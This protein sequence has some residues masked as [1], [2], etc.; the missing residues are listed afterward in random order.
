MRRKI[1]ICRQCK[2]FHESLTDFGYFC[3]EHMPM[4][5]SKPLSPLEFAEMWIPSNCEMLAEYCMEEWND[6]KKD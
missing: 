6:E 4:E 3:E 5:F 1:N 2:K